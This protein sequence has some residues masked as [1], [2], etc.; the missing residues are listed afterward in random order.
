MMTQIFKVISIL[1]L[2]LL[3]L[4]ARAESKYSIA[5]TELH[6]AKLADTKQV[7][8]KQFEDRELLV[9]FWR[10]DC[11]PCLEEMDILPDI[12]KENN[13]LPMVLIS[14]H[15]IEHTRSHLPTLPGNVHILVAEGDS[16]KILAEFGNER[17]LA[18]PYSIMLNANGDI[19]GKHYGILSPD[20]LKN[21]GSNVKNFY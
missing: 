12:A 10:S 8:L 3:S 19:C 1:A 6:G 21:G 16:K 4:N 9:A 5:F 14:L 7:T 18:L 13:D 15:D 17:I 20:K 11:A 2:L